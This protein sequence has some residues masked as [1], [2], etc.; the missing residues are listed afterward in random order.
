MKPSIR[1][2]MERCL[3]IFVVSAAA[4]TVVSS[5]QPNRDM[6]LLTDEPCAAPCW[7][8]IVPGVSSVED[9]RRVLET[10]V[11]VSE[12]GYSE[13]QQGKQT[14]L[15]LWHS[16]DC[17]ECTINT[18]SFED[19]VV[20]TISLAITHDLT[21]DDVLQK[22]GIPEGVT[23]GLGGLSE[24]KYLAVSLFYPSKGLTFVASVPL[25][26]PSLEPS[27]QVKH[28]SYSVPKSFDD[29]SAFPPEFLQRIEPWQG[30]GE[31]EVPDR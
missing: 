23:T 11:Y 19:N 5:C 16:A 7:Q 26:Q 14:K 25:D 6:S 4:I 24:R 8:G 9:A 1:S 2:Y 21:V 17:P 18:M 15:L 20:V 10:C 27:T 29:L 3:L 30:Y 12:G 22:F 31:L 28:A 13:E